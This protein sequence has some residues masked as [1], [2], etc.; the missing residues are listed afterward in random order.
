MLSKIKF[1]II[2][3]LVFVFLFSFSI[4]VSAQELRAQDDGSGFGG[5]SNRLPNPLGDNNNDPRV[6]IG[7]VIKA[8]LGIIG[9]LTLAFF[10]IGGF[11][12]ITSAG[13]DEKIKR[14][15]DIIIWSSFGLAL[16]FFSYAL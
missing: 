9:S 5:S 14:G 10:I 12:W 4:S 16:I 13:N 7:N 2:P 15:K 3:L 11:F 1:F 8:A 6:I